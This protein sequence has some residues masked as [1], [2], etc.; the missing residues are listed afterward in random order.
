MA[1]DRQMKILHYLTRHDMLEVTRLSEMLQT[2]PSTIRRELKV[3]EANGLLV[4]EHGNARLREPIRYEM[5]F[6]KRAIQQAEAKRKIAAMAKNLIKPGHVVGLSGGTTTT[7][8]ARQLRTVEN[9]TVVTSAINV[10]LELQGQS[11]K[12]VVVTGGILNQESYELM[13]DLTVQSLRN[14]H[15][16]F[17]FHSASGI[18]V[19][20]G[21]SLADEPDAVI[22]RAFKKATDQIIVIADHTKIGQRTF[23]R[24]CALAEIDLL[25]T[26]DG[27]TREQSLALEK[28]GLKVLIAAQ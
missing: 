22:A 1:T 27:L 17:V 14:I 8:L 13:G 25:I 11:S 23:A 16:D 15:L 12:R 26:D 5:P 7:E 10:A 19:D 21:V 24:F 9:I 3:M 20:F 28:A 4:R 2:S 6:E 18:D